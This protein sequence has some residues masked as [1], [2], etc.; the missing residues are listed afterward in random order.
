MKDIKSE[1][2][3]SV[4]KIL[5]TAGE[6]VE[7]DQEIMIL[8]SM[9]MEIPVFAPAY[10]KIAELKVTEGDAVNTDDVLAVLETQ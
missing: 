3:G 1:V 7:T 2:V 9:K 4:W 6:A 5:V 8:E 10:G